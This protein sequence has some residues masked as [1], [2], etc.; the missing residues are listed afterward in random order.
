MIK[1]HTADKIEPH[2]M[3]I[4]RYMGYKKSEPD[5]A[6]KEITKNLISE[7]SNII[8]YKACYDKYPVNIIDDTVNLGFISVN[9]KSLKRN[10][11]GCNEIILFTATLG[12]EFDRLLIK[13]S[14]SSPS[15]A[16]ILNAI[17]TAYIEAWCDKI[18]DDFKNAE[19]KM[20]NYLRPRFSPGYG[21]L[22]LDT[23]KD[24][25][26]VLDCNRKIGVSLTDS[27]LMTPS[28]SV[29]AIIGISK[30]N[31]NCALS[32]C[33]ECNNTNCKYRRSQK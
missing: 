9:S 5:K 8:T 24:I 4:Y 15:S 1:I 11:K 3:E 16:V 10:L 19:E 25:F 22:S 30:N 21:D 33:E 14:K 12:T 31:L 23:Q 20:E 26:S 2:I 13:Y 27:L 7:A 28:K 32:G 6:I 18:Y 29:S 17:G